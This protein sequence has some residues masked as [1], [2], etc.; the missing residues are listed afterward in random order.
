MPDRLDD[1]YGSVTSVRGPDVFLALHES[2]A[3]MTV[4][5]RGS[6]ADLTVIARDLM[7]TTC[8]EIV[9]T[10]GSDLQLRMLEP[11]RAV[12]R[13][14]HTRILISLA[15]NFRHMQ[16]SGCYGSWRSGVT[17]DVSAGGMCLVV[18]AGFET[19]RSVELLFNLP[20]PT[21]ES[22]PGVPVD[23]S[24]AEILRL[25]AVSRGSAQRG[26]N[27]ERSIRALAR[28]SRYTR[29]P[30]HRATMGLAFLTVSPTDQARLERFLNAP[31][32]KI[33]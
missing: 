25:M 29:I 13:R 6:R 19:P 23:P 28:V 33:L 12:Q 14:R 21:M 30:E 7:Y 31:W 11:V 18:E 1:F 20:D 4:L 27:K 8:T 9:T 22:T 5:K 10:V 3:R 26:Q 2:P 16:A 15:V 17:M 24:D 32:H